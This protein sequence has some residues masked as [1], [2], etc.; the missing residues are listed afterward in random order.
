MM[1]IFHVLNLSTSVYALLLSLKWA[2]LVQPQSHLTSG[3]LA[4]RQNERRISR[5]NNCCFYTPTLLW[6]RQHYKFQIEGFPPSSD[7]K[8]SDSCD[9]LRV[10]CCQ[11]VMKLPFHNFPRNCRCNKR[12]IGILMRL[13]SFSVK[14][15]KCHFLFF[16]IHIV[17][18]LTCVWSGHFVPSSLI[19]LPLS[20]WLHLL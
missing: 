15:Q 7:K 1:S 8:A 2:V 9:R 16:R 10:V 6:C 14:K 3:W 11:K 17:A 13:A 4:W 20:G 19:R 5:E 18:K 12:K